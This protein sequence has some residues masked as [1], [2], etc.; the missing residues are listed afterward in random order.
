M[1]RVIL[2]GSLLVL[3]AVFSGAV[4]ARDGA[5]DRDP[6]F[7]DGPR[8]SGKSDAQQRS[9]KEWGRD[10]FERPSEGG[11]SERRTETRSAG[12]KLTGIIYSETDR[13]AIINGEA[14]REGGRVGDQRVV[15]I[16][17]RSVVL[18]SGSGGREELV[19][20]NF[21]VGN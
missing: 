18:T 13:I 14:V 6:F 4:S 9:T 10:P 16:K 21:S 3:S 15:G 17:S 2:Y 8:A 20:E 7:T 5:M 11:V 12:G 19:L 1:K